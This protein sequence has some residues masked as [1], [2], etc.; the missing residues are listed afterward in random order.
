MI[1]VSLAE[2]EVVDLSCDAYQNF[3]FTTSR[4]RLLM[5]M[6]QLAQV[7]SITA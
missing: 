5:A 2:A 7:E 6:K 1:D 4:E 3:N